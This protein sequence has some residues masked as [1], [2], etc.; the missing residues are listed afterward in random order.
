MERHTCGSWRPLGAISRFVGRDFQRIQSWRNREGHEAGE[1]TQRL[2]R[3]VS[4]A[5]HI[6]QPE[7]LRPGRP[8]AAPRLPLR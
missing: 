2:E 6:G 5:K 4:A 3:A 1:S 7:A 8:A